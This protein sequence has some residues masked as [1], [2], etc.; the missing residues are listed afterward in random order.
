MAKKKPETAP[1]APDDRAEVG[2]AVLAIF[3]ITL[4]AYWNSFRGAWVFDDLHSVVNKEVYET[5]L[6]NF[7]K[8]LGRLR[9]VVDLTFFFNRIFAGKDPFGHHVV[10]FA[11]HV[12]AAWFVL[13]I[14]R[15]TPGA[16]PFA[17]PA[18][19]VF[20]VHPLQTESVTYIAQ[21]AQSL[22]GLLELASF[23]CIARSATEA[24]R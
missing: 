21:R 17:L 20:A 5:T 9:A 1:F 6:A 14:L 15:R 13:G 23:Y 3:L 16:K 8:I 10:N 19:I 11:I 24:A 4:A 12:S 7:V 2:L 22:M 18:A